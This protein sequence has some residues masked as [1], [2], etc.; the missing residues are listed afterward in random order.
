MFP[1]MCLR[2]AQRFPRWAM[3]PA[4]GFLL[5]AGALPHAASD[6][7]VHMVTIEAMRF[8]PPALEVRAGDTV[9]WKNNDPFPH[10]V[11]ASDGSFDSGSIDSG[12][13]WQYTAKAAGT[14]PYV[15]TLHPTMKAVLIVK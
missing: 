8:S 7:D 6:G 10:T 14:H 13:A 4:A 15:C 3:L 12:S 2:A 11:T 5:G 1:R 9:V